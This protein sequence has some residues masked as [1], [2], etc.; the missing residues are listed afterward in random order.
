MKRKNPPQNTCSRTPRA[1]MEKEPVAE[2]QN[3]F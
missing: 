3:E 1:F 2:T